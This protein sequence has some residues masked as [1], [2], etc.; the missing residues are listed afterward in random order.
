[1]ALY[2]YGFDSCSACG[3]DWPDGALVCPNCRAEPGESDVDRS[4]R[5]AEEDAAPAPFQIVLTFENAET[6]QL[7][8]DEVGDEDAPFMIDGGSVTVDGATY[9]LWDE[10]DQAIAHTERLAPRE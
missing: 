9:P 2:P 3:E 1:M 8:L 6:L 10:F 5:L 7:A 4:L